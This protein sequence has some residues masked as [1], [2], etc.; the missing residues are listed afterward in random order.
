MPVNT[1]DPASRSYSLPLRTYQAA[2]GTVGES[3]LQVSQ[4]RLQ[5]TVSSKEWASGSKPNTK[6]RKSNRKMPSFNNAK[7]T[8]L[9]K[10]SDNSFSEMLAKLN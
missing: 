3:L 6:K 10:V 5:F 1:K 8:T 2:S 9:S 7:K 4:T